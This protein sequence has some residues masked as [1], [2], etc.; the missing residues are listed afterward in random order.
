MIGRLSVNK[1]LILHNLIYE[2]T[3]TF[4]QNPSMLF[5][6]TDNFKIDM[7]MHRPKSGQNNLKRIKLEDLH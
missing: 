4:N 7:E 5:V 2:F 1:M 6:E 3:A